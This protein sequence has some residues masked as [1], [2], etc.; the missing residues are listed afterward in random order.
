MGNKKNTDHFTYAIKFALF[1]IVSAAL[2]LLLVFIVSRYEPKLPSKIDEY[3]LQDNVTQESKITVVID[4][5]HGGEDGGASGANGILEKDIN[6]KV[7]EML[8]D[9]LK[10]NGVNVVMTR[11]ED[12]LL[13]DPSSDYKGRKKALDLAARLKI[14]KETPSCIFVSI[15]MNSFPQSQYSGLQ[16][17]YSKNNEESKKIADLIQT[18][19]RLYLQPENG[20]RTKPATSAIYLLD[21][22]EMPSVLVE[23]GFLSNYEECIR[24]ATDDYKQK[25]AFTIFCSLMDYIS[26]NNT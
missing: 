21:R 20:R 14:A 6:L 5:G 7:S 16:V 15:H 1:G 19:T 10:A 2:T 9:M 4:A 13:Y 24:L 3:V 17:Y 11:T 22:L 12:I 23:C 26:Q 8:C 25:L 18:N